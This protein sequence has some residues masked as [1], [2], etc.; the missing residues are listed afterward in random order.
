MRG[1]QPGRIAA[2][3]LVIA[4]CPE[5]SLG[6][7]ADSAATTGGSGGSAPCAE[8]L[9][10]SQPVVGFRNRSACCKH[11]DFQRVYQSGR[12]QFTET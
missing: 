5:G 6:A 9:K 10:T 2:E 11:A 12:R 3:F 7:A 8:W 4:A 1:R